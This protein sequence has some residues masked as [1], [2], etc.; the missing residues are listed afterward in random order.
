MTESTV[1]NLNFSPLRIRYIF[2]MRGEKKNDV[3]GLFYASDRRLIESSM[4]LENLIMFPRSVSEYYKSV[5]RKAFL[6]TIIGYN[7]FGVT[8]VFESKFNHETILWL[9]AFPLRVLIIT[10]DRVTDNTLKLLD[11]WVKRPLILVRTSE[12][13]SYLRDRFKSPVLSFQEFKLNLFETELANTVDVLMADE[14]YTKSLPWHAKQVEVIKQLPSLIRNQRK[15][16]F[17]EW[18]L[19][20][21][22]VIESLDLIINRNRGY[23]SFHQKEIESMPTLW[24][25]EMISC[26]YR[27]FAE[28]ALMEVLAYYENSELNDRDLIAL[29]IEKSAVIQILNGDYEKFEEIVAKFMKRYD[30]FTRNRGLIFW[31]P[32]INPYFHKKIFGVLNKAYSIKTGKRIPDRIVNALLRD[33]GYLLEFSP[34]TLLKDNKDKELE[35]LLLAVVGEYSREN[36]LLSFITTL[37]SL[38]NNRPRIKTQKMSSSF[39]GRMRLLQNL[40]RQDTIGPKTINKFIKLWKEFRRD[41]TNSIPEEIVILIGRLPRM[42]IQFFSD[43]PLEWIEINGTPIMFTRTISRLP[44][45]SPNGLLLHYQITEEPLKIS[46]E[47]GKTVVLLIDGILKKDQVKSFTRTTLDLLKSG[48]FSKMFDIYEEEV[49][50]KES[51]FQLIQE[52]KPFICVID[53]HAEY[54]VEDDVGYL[55]I[56]NYKWNPWVDRIPYAPPIMILNSC[57]TSVV[58]G[59]FNTAANGLLANGVRSIIATL[60]PVSAYV[61]SYICIRLFA[62]LMAAMTG[63]DKLLTWKEVVSKTI[64]LNHYLDYFLP[65]SLYLAEKKSEK[66]HRLD[67]FMFDYVAKW[68]TQK[69]KRGTPFEDV[70][71]NTVL[72]VLKEYDLSDEFERFMEQRGVLPETAFFVSL[73]TPESIEIWD[74]ERAKYLESMH[75]SS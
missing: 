68:N 8:F 72:A 67:N 24:L 33:T 45:T 63:E 64:A 55:H 58:D 37:F 50:D 59:T 66:K 16:I 13:A 42:S 3:D 11:D 61:A 30:L 12:F 14:N 44:L 5:P 43:L 57:Q 19:R 62:N 22:R 73:G 65:F 28:M 9:N 21:N 38:R 75:D 4:F 54:N 1:N 35:R 51:L 15:S 56:G 2:L 17:P 6:N 48:D 29:D 71:F 53:A 52:K 23:I 34:Q 18:V 70:V 31:C 74:T 40:L 60:F 7:S 39:F 10:E 26:V 69:V 27:C 46:P 20:K 36:S 49:F 32:S 25:Q 41:I 47:F